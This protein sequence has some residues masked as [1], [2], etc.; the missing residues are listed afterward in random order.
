[1]EKQLPL[2]TLLLIFLLSSCS[3]ETGNLVSKNRKLSKKTRLALVQKEANKI[4]HKV[5]PF[6]ESMAAVLARS[7]LGI[8][9]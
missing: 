6:H 4:Y 2:I 8:H 5:L 3:Q 7:S 1:M 9:Q